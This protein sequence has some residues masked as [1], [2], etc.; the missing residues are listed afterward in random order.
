[1]IIVVMDTNTKSRIKLAIYT[2]ILFLL[3]GIFGWA[4]ANQT[5][6]ASAYHFYQAQIYDLNIKCGNHQMIGI[7][8]TN[9]SGLKY[10]NIS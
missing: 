1:M 3:G 8:S 5:A 2:L 6:Y 4:L 9:L 7:P 10:G